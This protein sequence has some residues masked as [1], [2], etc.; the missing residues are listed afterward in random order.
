MLEGS[1][2]PT[3]QV[4]DDNFP[5]TRVFMLCCAFANNRREE[6]LAYRAIASKMVLK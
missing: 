5:F 3:N 1:V 4:E 2:F 6:L